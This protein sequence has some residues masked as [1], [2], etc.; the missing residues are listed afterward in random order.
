M[1]IFLFSFSG[2]ICA[3]N[4]KDVCSVNEMNFSGGEDS[5]YLQSGS[6]P[7]S[8]SSKGSACGRKIDLMVKNKHE[9]ELAYCEFKAVHY[10]ALIEYQQSK[11]LRLNQRIMIEMKKLGVNE[12]LIA[13]NWE[14]KLDILCFYICLSNI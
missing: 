1:L 2:E 3:V 10:R 11:N 9:Q 4:T 8:R 14:G 7:L 13:F 5:S 12:K 6:L